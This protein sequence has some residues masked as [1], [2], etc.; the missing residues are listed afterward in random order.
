MKTKSLFSLASLLLGVQLA[1]AQGTSFTYQGRLNDGANPANGRYDFQ[2]QVFDAVNGGGSYGS[3]N[4]NTITNVA[5]NN[6]LF[7]VALDF[8]VGVFTGPDRWLQISARTNGAAS[9]GALTPRQKLT[10]APYA[11]YAANASQVGGFSAGSFVSKAGDTMTGGLNLPANGL[12]LAGGQ[13]FTSGG[14]VYVGNALNVDYWGNNSNSISPGLTFG[15]ASGEGISSNRRGAVNQFGLDI[16]TS[17]SARLSIL[18]NGNVGI[19]TTAPLAKL[20]VQGT[21]GLNYNDI[22]LGAGNDGNHGLGYRGSVNG[23][24]IGVDGPFLYG[25]NGGCLGLSGPDYAALTW[26]YNGNIWISNNCSTASLNVRGNA[27][28]SGVTTTVGGLVIET[29]TSDPPS[30]ATGRIWI[31][32]DL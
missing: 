19:G 20:D 27:S 4:P 9:Y 23:G 1:A 2:F 30:P 7:T 31:R 28:V 18:N 32:T 5:V 12:N 24:A 26:D 29:R 17:G 15:Y 3:P 14:N 21:V 25:F 8:G 16:Y 6:G 22:H 13:L 10:P 11:I